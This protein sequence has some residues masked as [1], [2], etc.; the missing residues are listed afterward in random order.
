LSDFNRTERKA[1]LVAAGLIGLAA[2]GRLA[3]GPDRADVAWVS[4]SPALTSDTSSL[5]ESRSFSGGPGRL[6][7]DVEVALRREERAL[8][9]LSSGERLDPNQAPEEELRRLP[10]IGP[11]RARAILEERAR[12]AFESPEAVMRVPGIGPAT[13]ARIAPFL[14]VD[15]RAPEAPRAG[16]APM[17]GCGTDD[18]VDPNTATETGL[19]ALPG[20]GPALARR[21]VQ[22]REA[23]GLFAT[24]EALLRV[25]GIGPR[26]LERLRDRVCLSG[27]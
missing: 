23:D 11:A 1:L 3:I 16:V 24:P 22:S 14:T 18:R 26:L 5:T 27:S 12:V 10:G 21:I 2:F 17:G 7:E 8:T 9:P 15:G 20:I 19:R 4:A 13:Y 25:S 6:K